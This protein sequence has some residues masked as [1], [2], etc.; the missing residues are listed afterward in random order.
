M[1]PHLD[2][3]LLRDLK[4]LKGQ[5]AAVSIVMACGL[6]MMITTRSLIA[7]L[8]GTRADYYE[9][10]R[11]ADVFGSVKRAP[12]HLAARLAALPGVA[13][14]QTDI[15][16]QVTLDLPGVD[17]PASGLVRS[18]PDFGEPELNRPYLRRGRWLS[19]G[20]RRELLVG[21]AFAEANQL[22]PG[23][24]LALI[25]N[26]RRQDFRVAGI[27]LSP[28][29]IFESRPGAALPDN[30]TYGIFWMTYKEV[31]TAW[32]LYGAFNSFSLKLAPGAEVAPVLA[33][34]DELLK[35]YGGAGTYGRKDHPSHIRVT[36]EIRVLTT[37]SIGFPAIFLGVA[38]F[39]TNAVLSRLLALQREQI[40]ILKAFGFSNGQIVGHYLKF[41]GVI[42]LVGIGLGGL[43]GLLLGRWMVRLYDLFFRFPE[44]AF[45]LD[46]QAV[47]LAFGVGLLAVVAGVLGSVRRAARLPPAEAMRPEPPASFRPSFIEHPSLARLFSHSFRIAVRNLERRPVQALFTIAG[48]ALATALLI[49]PNTLKA[50]IANILDYQW[51]LVQRQDINLGFSEPA[52]IRTLHELERLP[53]VMHVEP[54]RSTAVKIHFQG[55]DRQIGLR[56]L[57]PGSAHSRAVDHDG[58]EITPGT[59]GL[60]VSA[61]LAEVL[62]ARIG[63]ELVL[64]ALMGKRTVQP[65]RLAGLADDFTGIAA[66]MDRR[67]INRFMGEGDIITGAS[68]TLD[69]AR[70]AEFLAA[71]K[72]VPRISWI[73][74]KETMRASFR[75]TTAQMMGMLTTM[76]LGMAVVVAFGVI[77]NN[78]RISLAER[79]R[80]LATLRVIG[81]TQ[82]EVGAVIVTELTLLALLAVPTGLL[83]GTGIAAA[84]IA[85]VNTETVRL[86]LVF[87]PYT[88]TFALIVV[89][90]AST[91]SAMVVLRKLKHLDL[92]GALKAPE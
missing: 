14:V 6:A 4:R 21:E 75:Q 29:Y 36:D 34:A 76:Y 18:L 41:A 11:F 12:N 17:E 25:M 2:R 70:R 27:V 71:V 56:S 57:D 24:T 63:D 3:K 66:Y 85:S 80:E 13:G 37:L 53:G 30:R 32:D 67:A 15:A 20:S 51:D 68:F 39:M 45:R 84:I 26:G 46:H 78:A 79:A 72:E 40:A 86:P 87:T 81:M 8:D 74:I 23:D 10:N 44:L 1:L 35:P 90:A 82:R 9:S 16:G 65:V 73:A 43:G 77:Y 22:N 89:A 54:A 33:A 91:V 49:L 47:V 52:A 58:R 31:A 5:V 55:R 59:E 7:S 42:G 62:G 61:K 60:I 28:E 48:L 19:A 83:L 64:E 69:M 88:Y 38:A 50:G 92:I